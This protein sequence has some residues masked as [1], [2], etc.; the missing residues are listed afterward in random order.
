MP[1]LVPIVEGDGEV[2]AVPV[3]LYKLLH[4]MN[5]YDLQVA[6]PKNAHGRHNLQ[7]PNGLEKFVKHAWK[8]RECGAI[9]ILLDA[10]EECP[11]D[12]IKDFFKRVTA[13]GV[14]HPVVIVCAK[15]MYETWLLASS[16]TI[17]LPIES[18]LAKDPESVKNPKRLFNEHFPPGRIYKETEDQVAMTNKLDTALAKERSRSFRRLC[19]ALEQAIEALDN[20]AKIVTPSLAE[21]PASISKRGKRRKS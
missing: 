16:E 13:L 7:K 10:E 20:G 6:P 9:V 2:M 21:P 8:E 1:K 18:T 4:A 5:R 3:L 19:H 15:R 11:V 14:L 17:G 12:V